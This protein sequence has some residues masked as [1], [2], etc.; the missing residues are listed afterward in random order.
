MTA[1]GARSAV[2]QLGYLAADATR[3]Q[4]AR[5][6]QERALALWTEFIPNT[7]WC[8]AVLLELADLDAALGE[9]GPV[10]GRLQQ[11]L[12]IFLQVRDRLGVAYCEQALRDREHGD[13]GGITPP[14]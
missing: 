4:E 8:A 14:P 1:P 13:N 10:P 3:L 6:L 5:E 7:P 12:A 11:A 2:M 9:P